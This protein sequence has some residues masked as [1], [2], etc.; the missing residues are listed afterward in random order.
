MTRCEINIII[1]SSTHHDDDDDDK[2]DDDD[3]NY[4]DDDGD[5]D[6]DVLKHV[7]IPECGQCDGALVAAR[8]QDT[9]PQNDDDCDDDDCD[10]DR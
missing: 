6:G 4:D 10:D 5:D 2:D 7:H 3:D 9:L 1:I 8:S